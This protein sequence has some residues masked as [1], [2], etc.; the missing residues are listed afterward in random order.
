MFPVFRVF[1]K[2][3]GWGRLYGALSDLRGRAFTPYLP[4]KRLVPVACHVGCS[5]S[6]CGSCPS[7]IFCLSKAQLGGPFIF[8]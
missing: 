1:R 4:D 3:L 5:S 7:S 2:S 6:L 8:L